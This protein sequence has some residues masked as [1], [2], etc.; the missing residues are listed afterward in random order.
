MDSRER[1]WEEV[2]FFVVPAEV[3][4][5]EIIAALG[6][7]ATRQPTRARR[8]ALAETLHLG[9]QR[10]G[11]EED[12][13]IFSHGGFTWVAPP[14]MVFA[15]TGEL[16]WPTALSTEF[17]ACHVFT[18]TIG[19]PGVHEFRDGE[20]T[21]EVTEFS[22]RPESGVLGITDRISDVVTVLDALERHT[23]SELRDVFGSG[24]AAFWKRA[25]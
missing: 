18:T 6:I 13:A 16:T 9:D 21:G 3:S 12:L 10:G 2:T 8:F 23:G 11:S 1:L 17:G 15:R 19:A 7:E 25:L 14:A 20:H 22:V 5:E 24:E 4:D